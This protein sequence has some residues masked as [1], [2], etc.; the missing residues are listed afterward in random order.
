MGVAFHVVIEVDEAPILKVESVL[1]HVLFVSVIN[2]RKMRWASECRFENCNVVSCVFFIVTHALTTLKIISIVFRALTAF[3]RAWTVLRAF[4]FL[5]SAILLIIP[6]FAFKFAHGSFGKLQDNSEN[7]LEILVKHFPFVF[8]YLSLNLASEVV[9]AIGVILLEFTVIQ[10]FEV[11]ILKVTHEVIVV[12]ARVEFVQ[13]GSQSELLHGWNIVVVEIGVILRPIQVHALN[14][15]FV[16]QERFPFSGRRSVFQIA[17]LVEVF[18]ELIGKVRLNELTNGFWVPFSDCIKKF[19]DIS[20]KV[21]CD[22]F[23]LQVLAFEVVFNHGSWWHDWKNQSTLS[24]NW[25]EAIVDILD[26]LALHL[27]DLTQGLTSLGCILL[28]DTL[29]HI[30]IFELRAFR[31]HTSLDWENRAH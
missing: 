5:L 30:V 26:L 16:Y 24:I 14:K 22:D 17:S 29:Q 6:W 8:F 15:K 18:D 12:V 1:V 3:R 2:H 4:T 20:L 11:A 27:A 25:N 13:E 21:L 23:V 10:L 28:I 9:V 31:E 19:F 7:E